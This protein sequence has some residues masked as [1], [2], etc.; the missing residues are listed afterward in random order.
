MHGTSEA[1][2]TCMSVASFKSD[3]NLAFY[4]VT[5]ALTLP[6]SRLYCYNIQSILTDKLLLEIY[7]MEVIRV[8]TACVRILI[9]VHT[10]LAAS[11]IR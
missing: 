2:R 4:K 3:I 6:I 7:H 5:A 8:M 10:E 9:L 1:D 11:N